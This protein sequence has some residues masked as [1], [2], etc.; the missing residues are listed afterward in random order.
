MLCSDLEA[1][2]AWPAFLEPIG[3]VV[4][5]SAP[6]AQGMERTINWTIETP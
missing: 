5:G 6:Q 3:R 4:A 1:L 2:A